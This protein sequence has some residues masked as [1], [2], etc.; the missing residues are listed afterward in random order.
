M[1]AFLLQYLPIAIFFAI[2]SGDNSKALV[3]VL[4]VVAISFA[5]LAAFSICTRQRAFLS[6]SI[7]GAMAGTASA[8][9]PETRGSRA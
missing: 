3:W 4:I 7:T 5:V 2:E 8:A 6:R 9:T 1:N